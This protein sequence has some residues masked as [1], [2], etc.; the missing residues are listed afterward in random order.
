[1][2]K[3]IVFIVNIKEEGDRKHRS[4]PYGYSIQSWQKWCNK[5]NC[6]LFVLEER[7]YP[8]EIMNANWHKL[9]V[10]DLLEANDID[11]NQILIVDA[12]TIIHPDAPNIFG[13]SE[14]KFCAVRVYGSMDWV[15]RSYENYKK[16]L[17]P[18]VEYSPL[19]YFNSGVLLMNKSHK[20]FYKKIVEFYLNNSELIQN[21]QKTFGVG[22]DQPV[23]NFF[24]RQE[25]IDLKLLPYEW[26][27]QD[28]FRFE[29]LDNQL[30][31][32][33]HGWLYHFN[34]IPNNSDGQYTHHFMKSTTQKLQIQ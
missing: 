3:N 23:I 2:S 9:F 1:M 13:L 32:T 28:L 30:S 14:N 26:N 12:D 6:E 29:I 4:I 17:F 24:V 8:K 7:I 11:Y 10:F 20:E 27:M 22:T 25:N 33:D 34:A 16:H 19:D 5:N 21:I 15:C 18:E 31:Y